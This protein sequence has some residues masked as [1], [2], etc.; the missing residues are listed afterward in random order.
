MV[1]RRDAFGDVFLAKGM[2]G[3]AK[4]VS[5]VGTIMPT[6]ERLIAASLYVARHIASTCSSTT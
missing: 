2:E 6:A 1:G 3:L 5:I 4:M